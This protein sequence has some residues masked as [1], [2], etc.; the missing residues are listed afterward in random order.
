MTDIA[1]VWKDVA[2]DWQMSGSQLASGGDLVTAVLI[3]VFSDR[4][5]NTDDVIVDGSNDPR[6]WWGDMGASYPVGSRIWLLS[7]A[8]KTADILLKAKDY[9]A[10]ALQW[11]IDDGVVVKFD[12]TTEWGEPN[13]LYA[14]VVAWRSDG[15]KVAQRFQW[16]WSSLL[17]G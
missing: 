11:L 15:S 7:R 9:L 17:P 1:T 4:L 16:V 8:K 13:A 12:I 14:S 10:E 5:A 2:G 6:G 3:S